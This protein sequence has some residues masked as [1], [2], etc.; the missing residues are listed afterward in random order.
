MNRLCSPPREMDV[1][2]TETE[3]LSEL[4]QHKHDLLEQLRELSRRQAALV[5]SEDLEKLLNVL[6]MKQ[7]L[8]DSLQQVEVRLHPFREQDPDRRQWNSP[9][10]RERCRR[11]A[12]RCE[13][14]LGEII[15]VERQSE[16]ELIARRDAAAARLQGLHQTTQAARAYR[17]NDPTSVRLDLSSD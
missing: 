5:G 9:Q 10:D 16:S 14:I 13:A 1:T 3:V 6:S 17:A 2:V 8:L 11:V 15:L 12:E 7:R 4:V